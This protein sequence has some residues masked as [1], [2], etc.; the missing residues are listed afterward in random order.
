MDLAGADLRRA[1][2]RGANCKETRLHDA[3]LRGADL[4]HAD[5]SGATGLIEQ[6]LAGANLA[7]LR[8]PQGTLDERSF[9]RVREAIRGA[10][11]LFGL[12]LLLSLYLLLGVIGTEALS[13]LSDAVPRYLPLTRTPF[14]VTVFHLVAPMLLLGLYAYLLL[15]VHGVWDSMVKLPAV[16]P[17]GRTPTSLLEPWF[18]EGFT[19]AHLG[20]SNKPRLALIAT[21]RRL[22]ALLAWWVVPFTCT[23]VWL[24]Y[25]RR[26]DPAGTSLHVAL[27]TLAV[28]CGMLSYRHGIVTLSG[29]APPAEGSAPSMSG[30]W[31]PL[32]WKQRT[33]VALNCRAPTLR[34]PILK[35]RSLTMLSWRVPI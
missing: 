28:A 3:D 17:N 19:R 24:G 35:Q 2:L 21:Q 26:H 15:R 25:L 16:L 18:L 10:Q 12:K 5:L 29:A 7:G 27:L 22:A 6:R 20:G 30:R 8:L 14:P 1:D 23:V 13:L 4:Q 32:F 34:R 11:R 9:T 33:S 31:S